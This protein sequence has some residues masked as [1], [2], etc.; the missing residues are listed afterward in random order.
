MW[1]PKHAKKVFSWITFD[2]FHYE[3]E[4]FDGSFR[5]FEKLFRDHSINIIAITKDKKILI[6]REQQ[7][8]REEF[9]SIIWW[10][11]EDWETP[12]YTAERELLEETGMKC[13]ELVLLKRYRYSSRIE[14]DNYLYIARN[15][16]KIAEQNL[17]VWEKIKVIE[18]DWEEFK[19]YVIDENFR[20]KQLQVE[21]LRNIYLWKEEEFKKKLLG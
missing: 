7:P 9:L 18:C 20:E 21:L 14:H 17:E 19:E 6:L 11:W 12:E 2:V 1:I 4:M 8:G 3:Q 13:E 16:E 15:C 5:T 10:W